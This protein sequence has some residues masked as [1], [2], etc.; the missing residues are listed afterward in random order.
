MPRF[1]LA[2]FSPAANR[3]LNLELSALES[4]NNGRVVSSPRVVT[5]DLEKAF[6]KQ[7]QKVPFERLITGPQGAQ[8]VIEF[9][10]A[11]LSLEVVPQITPS[12]QVLLRIKA[13][14]NQLDGFRG[15]NPIVGVKEA[16]TEVMV[17][18]GGT[19]MIGG[20]FEAAELSSVDKVP[21]LGDVPVLGN[22]FKR[23]SSDVVKRELL[24]FVTPTIL[25]DSASL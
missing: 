25:A 16:E 6:I 1:A 8:T 20:I 5:G 9:I 15:N 4:D 10:D 2:L 19:V 12:N 14:K 21:V 11:V 7:G 23:R 18:N 22:F 24:I 3:F 13:A 17:E